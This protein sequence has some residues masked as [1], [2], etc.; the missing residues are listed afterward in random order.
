MAQKV[1]L[2]AMIPRAD[3]AS[4]S[5]DESSAEKIGPVAV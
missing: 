3:F 1:N 2:D 5:D 4:K